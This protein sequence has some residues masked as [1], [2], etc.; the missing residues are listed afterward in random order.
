MGLLSGI[1]KG[2][3]RGARG[4][5]GKVLRGIKSTYQKSVK[6]IKAGISKV[7]ELITGKKAPVP[8][9]EKT[10]SQQ[11]RDRGAFKPTAKP[12]VPY[13]PEIIVKNPRP[14]INKGRALND[15]I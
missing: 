7:K 4:I 12:K 11:L 13:E 5:G 6:G 14:I 8:P 3:V 9:K 2:I 15:P 1:I 10:L